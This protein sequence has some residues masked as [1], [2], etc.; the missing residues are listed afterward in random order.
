MALVHNDEVE[1]IAGVLLIE[2]RAVSVPGKALVD[3]EVHLAALDRFPF[4]LA[5]CIAEWRE[6]LVF[7]LI[8]ENIA[9]RKIEDSWT[10]I[11]TLS[12]PTRIPKFPANLEGHHSLSGTSGQGQQ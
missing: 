8:H 1:E 4:D 5:P 11:F 9:I 7:W 2:T 10:A 6:Y 12:I 3:R